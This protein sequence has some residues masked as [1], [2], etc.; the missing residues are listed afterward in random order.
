MSVNGAMVN[1]TD[2]SASIKTAA[3]KTN[4]RRRRAAPIVASSVLSN[5]PPGIRALTVMARSLDSPFTVADLHTPS[6]PINL[7]IDLLALLAPGSQLT[8]GSTSSETV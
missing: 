3:M 2:V 8:Q 1:T 6:G 5:T 4:Q 7:L